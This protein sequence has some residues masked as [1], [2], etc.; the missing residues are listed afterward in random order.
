MASTNEVIKRIG[1]S[2]RQ[3]DY[4]WRTGLI[5]GAV[6]NGSGVER[7]ITP[8]QEEYY[9]VVALLV[10]SGMSLTAVRE[11][12]MRYEETNPINTYSH[13]K[14]RFTFAYSIIKDTSDAEI[15]PFA[16]AN[17]EPTYQPPPDRAG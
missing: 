6:Q 7:E 4:W 17:D 11:I 15:I 9:T 3:A 10:D 5:P 8:L 2:Y 16:P 13:A 1:I 12:L 14:G